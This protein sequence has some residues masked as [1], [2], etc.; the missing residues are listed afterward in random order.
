MRN[1][2]L[3]LITGLMLL[4]IGCSQQSTSTDP[5]VISDDSNSEIEASIERLINQYAP[6]T[7]ELETVLPT[8][9]LDLPDGEADGNFDIY[10]V[11]FLWGTLGWD[12]PP[13]GGTIDWTGTLSVNGVAIIHPVFVI[14]FEH[15]QDSLIE[16]D[17]PYYAAWASHTH[18]DFDGISFLVLLDRDVDYFTPPLLTFDT[19]PFTISYDF[20]ELI[21]LNA[22]HEVDSTNGVAVHARRIWHHSC[23][24][25]LIEGVWSK[26]D[27]FAGQGTFEG[28]W[29]DHAGNPTG[30]LS[31]VFWTDETHHGRFSGSV[32][33]IDTDEVIAELQ[34]GWH[35]DDHRLC[36]VC[37]Y[38]HGVFHG[39]F[40]RLHDDRMGTVHGQFGDLSLPWD[41]L[42]LPMAGIWRFNCPHGDQ[43]MDR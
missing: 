22:F 13:D 28:T 9:G 17:A 18:N 21:H 41:Q 31:G 7:E 5:A 33:G 24:G 11:T 34:G 1:L 39:H 2:M 8:A 30:L 35:Y 29:R 23:P 19:G 36:P 6:D 3:F 25:G 40:T 12:G 26:D 37:G 15:D 4:A 16:A 27:P 42:G 38:G 43:A 14:D 20:S 10:S 32:S